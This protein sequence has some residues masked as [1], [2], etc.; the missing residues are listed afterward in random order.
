MR[1]SVLGE[2]EVSFVRW[3]K[4][5]AV[6][7]VTIATARAILSSELDETHT[8][9]PSATQYWSAVIATPPPMPVMKTFCPL[10]TFALV[11][12]ALQVCQR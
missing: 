5:A 1:A 8:L 2:G 6:R 7:E 4:S 10:C 12:T 9:A 3:R 11:N